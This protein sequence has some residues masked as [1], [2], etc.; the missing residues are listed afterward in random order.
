MNLDDKLKPILGWHEGSEDIEAKQI[1]EIKQAFLDAGWRE[2]A[3]KMP[4]DNKERMTG[5][6]WYDKFTA[7]VNPMNE[8]VQRSKGL[9]DSYKETQQKL[10]EVYLEAARR[11][12]RLDQ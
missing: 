10:H 9:F 8:M 11:I 1:A 4:M 5:Q 3:Y 7:L 6:E 2:V 12:A